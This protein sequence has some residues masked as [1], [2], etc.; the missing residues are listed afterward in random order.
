MYQPII[1][2]IINELLKGPL[3]GYKLS[4]ILLKKG[5][6][7]HEI[8]TVLLELSGGGIVKTDKYWR[9]YLNPSVDAD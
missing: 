1:G 6:E 3:E 7:S 2:I 8:M 5:F 4:N 9:T